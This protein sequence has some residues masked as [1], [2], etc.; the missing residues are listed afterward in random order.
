M[1]A[2]TSLRSLTLAGIAHRCGQETERFFGRSDYDPRPC[3]ELFR[4]ALAERNQGAYELLYLQYQPL[5]ASWV[6]RH[7]GFAALDEEVQ[8]F[9]NRAFEKLWR[10]VTP[11]KFERF[12]DL[13]S[14]LSYLKACTASVII[15]YARA[16][17]PSVVD[18][19][20]ADLPAAAQAVEV[21]PEE[22]V[23]AQA[24]QQALWQFIETRLNDHKE[25]AVL[26]GAFVLGLKPR[27]L[28]RK[29]P[30]TFADV[31][32]VYRT[33]QNLVERL[34]RDKQLREFASDLA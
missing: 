26:Y 34:R 9:V 30:T 4:R 32:D 20:P 15:D 31:N 18:E 29:F 16:G 21:G 1:S 33:K 17:K 8:Y 25:R 23:M 10:A 14:L 22:H 3:F 7:A 11:E 13:K 19:E 24:Q 2:E 27:D 28:C 6:E 12:A 5:V